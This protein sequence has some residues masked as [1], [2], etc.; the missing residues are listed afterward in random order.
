MNK[1]CID[2]SSSGE[3]TRDCKVAVEELSVVARRLTDD[4]SIPNNPDLPLLV[5]RQAVALAEE[6]PAAVFEALFTANAWPAAWRNG[7]HPFHHYHSTAHEALGVFSGRATACFGGEAGV[8]VT[9]AAGDVI[10]IPAGVGHKGI[11]ATS[12]LGIV[13]A[14]PAGTGPDLCRGLAGER[15]ACLEEIA[16]VPVPRNDPLYGARG[17][18][19]EHWTRHR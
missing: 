14:Y 12:D 6:D 16:R 7:I 1:S 13:G 4:G 8:R 17:P 18:L 5:Y 11:E 19:S 15:P 3:S 2:A 9:V 10:I